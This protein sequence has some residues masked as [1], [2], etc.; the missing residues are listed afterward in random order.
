M[1]EEFEKEV[2][3]L[4]QEEILVPWNDK[5]DVIPLI[6]VEQFFKCHTGE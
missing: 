4:I 3:L 1:K 6:A 5:E 2:N